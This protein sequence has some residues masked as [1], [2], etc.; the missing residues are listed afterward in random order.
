MNAKRYKKNA[1]NSYILY[2]VLIIFIGLLIYSGYNIV[3]WKFN[4]DKNR[5][6]KEET[7]QYVTIVQEETANNETQNKIRVDFIALKQRNPD[8][9]AW[10]KIN[11]TQIDYPVVQGKDNSY[12]LTH[13]MDKEY[14]KA[15]WIFLDYRN[16]LNENDKNT[17]IYGHN[18]KT[19][20]MFGT[21]KNVLTDEWNENIENRHITLITE[22]E[23][24]VYE[25]FSI[26][27]IEEEEYSIKIDFKNAEEYLT[28]LN[29]IKQR[30]IKNFNV[31]LT[32]E[33]RIL[34]LSTCTNDSYHRLVVHAKK[35]EN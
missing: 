4:N 35:L 24:Q 27:E 20:L 19:D 30:S 17:V 32:T 14:N 13:N 5:Q 25:V 7:S 11:N 2:L 21:L 31:E 6:I 3:E 28:F 33:N 15:G 9:V 34:T 18:M 10:I 23:T 8:V 1:K 12:Y 16:E 22:Q 29:T 26:Y